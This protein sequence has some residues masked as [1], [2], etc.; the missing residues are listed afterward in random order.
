M[1]V[2]DLLFHEATDVRRR[3]RERERE[4]AI[5]LGDRF[6]FRFDRLWRRDAGQLFGRRPLIPFPPPPLTPP[7]PPQ[8]LFSDFIG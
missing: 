7:L 1:G 3:E 5:R 8:R 6:V 2:E 4:A